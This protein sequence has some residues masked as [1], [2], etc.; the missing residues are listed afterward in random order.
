MH[1]RL[2]DE[3]AKRFYYCWAFGQIMISLCIYLHILNMCRAAYFR[4]NANTLRKH[5]RRGYIG[6]WPCLAASP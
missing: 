5:M 6:A 1:G 4:A 2:T 3:Y